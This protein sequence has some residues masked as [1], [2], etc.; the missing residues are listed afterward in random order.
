M[1]F[2]LPELKFGTGALEP[3]IDEQTMIIHHQKHHGAYVSNLNAAV[4]KYDALSEW[5][6]ESLLKK[7]DEVPEDI[8]MT[9][10]NNGG[11][12]YNH[13]LFWE[14]LTPDY[15]DPSDQMMKLIVDAFGSFE[16]MQAEFKDAALKRF[17]S[18]WAWLVKGDGGLKIMS[19]PNQDAPI[20]EGYVE[21]LGIDVWEHA[22][23][24]NYQNKRA[25]YIDAFWNVVNWAVVE[26]R[27]NKI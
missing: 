23:Y 12:H 11:G 27:F 6:V 17:G 3:Y 19:T 13:T 4:E 22:Y 24:L 9:V 5:T 18:G 20:S 14:S 8:R 26:E 21:L 7:L 25:D 10:R 1:K 2:T 15:K 16:V